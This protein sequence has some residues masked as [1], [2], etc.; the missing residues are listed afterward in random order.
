MKRVAV[1]LIYQFKIRNN[2]K[3]HIAQNLL[4]FL[5]LAQTASIVK[6]LELAQ[7][8]AVAEPNDYLQGMSLGCTGDLNNYYFN[9]KGL[10]RELSM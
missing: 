5:A 7:E 2:N 8:V 10:T 6:S 4:T 9:L 1:K 3:M